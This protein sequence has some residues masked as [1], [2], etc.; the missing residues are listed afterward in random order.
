MHVLIPATLR[1]VFGR[2]EK[3]DG[4]E[5]VRTFIQF[6]QTRKTKEGETFLDSDNLE[7]PA[8]LRK[9]FEAKIGKEITIPCTPY[10]FKET[11]KVFYSF[12]EMEGPSH[13]EE[14]SPPPPNRDVPF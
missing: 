12:I 8:R 9:T 5:R 1:N 4:K 11:K 6:E 7:I 3:K 2:T 10:T 14:K 13:R